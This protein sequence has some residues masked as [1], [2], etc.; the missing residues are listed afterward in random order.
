MV[1][2]ATLTLGSLTRKILSYFDRD[3]S[4]LGYNKSSFQCNWVV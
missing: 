2:S 4:C 1:E 3:R